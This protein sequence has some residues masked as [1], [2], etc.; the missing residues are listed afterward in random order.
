VCSSDLPGKDHLLLLDFLWLADRHDLC[1]PA[2]LIAKDEDI[3][4][5]IKKELAG[6]QMS[7]DLQDAEA[8]AQ[9]S[10]AADREEALAKALEEQRHKKRKLVDPLQFAASISAADLLNY[11]PELGWDKPVTS[12]QKE[13]LEKFGIYPDEITTN[14]YA[15]ALIRRLSDRRRNGYAS[16]KQIRLLEGRGFQHVGQWS[17]QD[18]SKMIDRIA[19]AGWRIPKGVNPATYRP[20]PHPETEDRDGWNPIRNVF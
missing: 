5:R 12:S 1:R 13:Q 7:L 9:A 6:Q 8:D 15:D 11:V 10:A 19:F 20:E 14:G 17:L 3:R 18:A 4:E 2:D 16:P